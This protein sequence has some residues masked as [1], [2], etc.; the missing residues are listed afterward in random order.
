[1]APSM[2][3]DLPLPEYDSVESRLDLEEICL[4]V[5]TDAAEAARLYWLQTHT[6]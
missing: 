6:A 3:Q 1:M 2:Q 4:L 5:D